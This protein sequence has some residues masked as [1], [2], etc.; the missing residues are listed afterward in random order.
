MGVRYA[1]F[2]CLFICFKGKIRQ[3][4]RQPDFHS[5][6]SITKNRDYRQLYFQHF[7]VCGAPSSQYTYMLSLPSKKEACHT[8]FHLWTHI[9][10]LKILDCRPVKSESLRKG[11]GILTL[12][13]LPPLLFTPFAHAVYFLPPPNQRSH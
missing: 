1:F 7:P 12:S 9:R 3:R 5:L 13:S 2:V 6:E 11:P 8:E 10:A 4:Q